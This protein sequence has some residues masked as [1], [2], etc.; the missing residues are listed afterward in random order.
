MTKQERLEWEAKYLRPKT[1]E[2]FRAMLG[3]PTAFE[4]SM[5]GNLRYS[6]GEWVYHNPGNSETA[7]DSYDYRD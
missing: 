4:R 1:P 7:G 5:R 3:H 6:N 2:E